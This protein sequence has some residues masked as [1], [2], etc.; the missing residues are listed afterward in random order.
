MALKVAPWEVKTITTLIRG[1]LWSG[2][3]VASGGRCAVAWV[4]TCCPKEFGGLGIPNLEMMGM[5]LHMRWLWF[6]RTD[7]ERAWSGFKFGN[8]VQA[9][10]FSRLPSRSRSEMGGEPCSGW[11]TR[12]KAPLFIP[13]PPTFG[14]QCLGGFV[15]LALL[16]M[17]P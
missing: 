16:G 15:I 10:S 9:E 12:F 1:F 7:P 5:V 4:N 6:A 2:S 11:I 13:S 14:R 8:E 17:H 3:E